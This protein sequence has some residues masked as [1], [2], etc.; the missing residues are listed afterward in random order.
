MKRIIYFAMLLIGIQAVNAKTAPARGNFK[1][2]VFSTLNI[3]FNPSKS[4]SQ[5][6]S[7]E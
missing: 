6:A 2:N 1:A 5:P 3:L 4:A 7:N